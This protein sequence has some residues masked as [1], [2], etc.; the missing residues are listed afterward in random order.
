MDPKC[1]CCLSP[2]TLNSA[3]SRIKWASK[4]VKMKIIPVV[5]HKF[6]FCC[7]YQHSL[8]KVL[9]FS[10]VL[11]YLTVL[12]WTWGL[13]TEEV[14]FLNLSSTTQLW[15][16]PRSSNPSQRATTPTYRNTRHRNDE[17]LLCILA[18]Q[19]SFDSHLMTLICH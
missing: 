9:V 13:M 1:N 14:H 10:Q 12:D 8:L 15:S 11:T 19:S 17:Y 3:K 7:I 2:I 5:I 4:F 18:L 6:Q 16:S